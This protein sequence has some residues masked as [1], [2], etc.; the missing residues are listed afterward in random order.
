MAKTTSTERRSKVAEAC[1][2][3][4]GDLLKARTSSVSSDD[5]QES[6]KDLFRWFESQDAFSEGNYGIAIHAVEFGAEVLR[7]RKTATVEEAIEAIQGI[8]KELAE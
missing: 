1:L 8:Y 2:S 7:N 5:A 6:V 3:F 4:G